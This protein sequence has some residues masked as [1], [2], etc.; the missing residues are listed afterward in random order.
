M[1]YYS[2][3][4]VRNRFSYGTEE[5]ARATG[6]TVEVVRDHKRDGRL[7]IEDFV[8]VCEYVVGKRLLGKKEVRS[9]HGKGS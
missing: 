8:S 2:P 9:D 6:Q 4:N 3:M 1:V 7:K 5:I